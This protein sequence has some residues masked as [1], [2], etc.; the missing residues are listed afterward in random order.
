MQININF[1][2]QVGNQP[3]LLCFLLASFHKCCN[4]TLFLFAPL[5]WI[6]LYCTLFY[7]LFL[8]PFFLSF[9]P[10]FLPSFLYILG[11]PVVPCI[12]TYSP[13]FLH[14]VRIRCQTSTLGFKVNQRHLTMF[15]SE[16]FDLYHAIITPQLPMFQFSPPSTGRHTAFLVLT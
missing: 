1:V 6:L 13:A 15:S 12:T 4:F 9:T 3:R 5:S 11:R 7:S 16:Y 8:F 2:H 14:E 10:F